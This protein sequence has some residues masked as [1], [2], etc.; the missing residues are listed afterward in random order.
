M[1][2][3]S[4]GMKV[5]ASSQRATRPSYALL[6]NQDGRA[7]RIVANIVLGED[8][9]HFPATEMFASNAR[10]IGCLNANIISSCTQ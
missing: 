6:L 1:G 5:H 10:S 3:S 8:C 4:L 7:I 2:V 9:W